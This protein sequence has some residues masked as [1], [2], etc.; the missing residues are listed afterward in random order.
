MSATQGASRKG[1]VAEE[2]KEEAASDLS[3]TWLGSSSGAPTRQRNVSC[4]ALD[5]GKSGVLLVDCGEGSKRQLARYRGRVGPPLPCPGKTHQR[6]LVSCFCFCQD[7]H[8][9]RLPPPIRS[10]IDMLQI[11]HI[12][13]THMHG[14][15]CFGIPGLLTALSYAKAGDPEQ[16]Q[17]PLYI[18]GPPGV[19]EWV[20]DTL[21]ARLLAAI[22]RKLFIYRAA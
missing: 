5:M 2:S 4:I 16:E 12:C 11:R 17:T 10:Q 18:Y 1:H 6:R 13:V 20:H 3:V 7:S 8:P 9:L 19:F 15:H 21:Q 14:D 22:L